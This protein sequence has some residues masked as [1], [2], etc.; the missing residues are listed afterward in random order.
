[1]SCVMDTDFRVRFVGLLGRGNELNEPLSVEHSGRL[2]TNDL[3]ARQ[4]VWMDGD[5]LF[6]CFARRLSVV[7]DV[8]MAISLL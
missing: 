4:S 7:A 8:T 3:P 1:M 2:I 6:L 5:R